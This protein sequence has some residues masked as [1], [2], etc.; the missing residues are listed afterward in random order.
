MRGWVGLIVASAGS[1]GAVW[2]LCVRIRDNRRNG[3]S[4]TEAI[5]APERGPSLIAFYICVA[6]VILGGVLS[7]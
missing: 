2:S 4:L 7:E 6:L 5:W 3:A 1:I